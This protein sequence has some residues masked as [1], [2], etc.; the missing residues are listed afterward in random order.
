M[1]CEDAIKLAFKH[2]NLKSLFKTNGELNKS[3]IITRDCRVLPNDKNTLLLGVIYDI[4]DNPT[5]DDKK[6]IV[7]M[8]DIVCLLYTSRCV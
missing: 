4:P 7:V 2:F 6:S 5:S 8:V 3:N 1:G